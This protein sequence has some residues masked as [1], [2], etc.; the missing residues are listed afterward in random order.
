M[1]PEPNR[2]ASEIGPEML[3]L[4]VAVV[5]IALPDCINPT[6][7][8][9]ELFVATGSHPRRRT[10]LFTLSA[11]TVTFLFGLAFALGLG[12]FIL[13]R[14]PKPGP[15]LKYSLIGAAGVVLIVGGAGVWIRRRALVEQDAKEQR[16]ESH[17]SSGL[18][19]AGIAGLELLTAFPY[20]AAIAMIVGSGVSNASKLSLLVLYCVVY[21]LPLIVIAL[22]FAVMGERAERIVRPVGD[23]LF[24]HWP[25]LVG[26]LTMAIGIAV[27]SFGIVELASL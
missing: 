6:L 17:G 11:W 3:K 5:A 8:G 7:I 12:D 25:L 9:G 2:A 16:R 13:S 18:L 23:W 1:R 10:A 27:L 21:S 14:V 4:A 20:F 26:P 22:I 19:G 15:T 24:A